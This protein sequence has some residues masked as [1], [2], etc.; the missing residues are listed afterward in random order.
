MYHELEYLKI[1]LDTVTD[2]NE[3]LNTV[4][5]DNS[6][7]DIDLGMRKIFIVSLVIMIMRACIYLLFEFYLRNPVVP[8]LVIKMVL[9]IFLK[10]PNHVVEVM[11]VFI[12]L[13]LILKVVQSGVYHKCLW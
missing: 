9:T 3:T 13:L 7:I 8:C 12:V 2:M 5:G 10:I 11:F 4:P 1:C 6:D